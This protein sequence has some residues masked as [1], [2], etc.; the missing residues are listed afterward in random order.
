LWLILAGCAALGPVGAIDRDVV[1]E[2]TVVAQALA[3]AKCGPAGELE[4]RSDGPRPG[5]PSRAADREKLDDLPALER[6]DVRASGHLQGVPDTIRGLSLRALAG[7]SV[8]V[9]AYYK[10]GEFRLSMT[11]AECMRG[12]GYILHEVKPGNGNNADIV[13]E[14][15]GDLAL[16]VAFGPYEGAMA[17]EPEMSEGLRPYGVWWSGEGADWYLKAATDDS[18]DV[19]DFARAIACG[20]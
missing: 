14:Q 10:D 7:D 15:A 19:L 20:S 3:D 16:R 11:R 9:L 17:H 1:P 13:V 12:G 4:L 2:A 18:A 8:R 6:Q 5:R